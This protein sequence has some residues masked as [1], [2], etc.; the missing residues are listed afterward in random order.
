MQD[1]R[2]LLGHAL[3]AVASLN[4]HGGLFCNTPKVELCCGGHTVFA[5]LEI[6]HKGW[7]KYPLVTRAWAHQEHLLSLRTLHFTE[8]KLIWECREHTNCQC[9]L[10]ARKHLFEGI[11][12]R[13]KLHSVGLTNSTINMV[14]KW[15]DIMATYTGLKLTKHT[16]KLMA[17]D[18][19]AHHTSR[20]RGSQYVYGA[21]EDTFAVNL[22]WP[23][24]SS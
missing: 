17:I 24:L 21:F 20:T 12:V 15:H 23:G 2:E 19:L 18:G 3:A 7:H 9:S 6:N 10:S 8:H 14:I 16:D 4:G 11:P 5:E 1:V 13:T 22:A